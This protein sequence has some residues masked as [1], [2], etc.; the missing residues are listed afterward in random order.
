MAGHPTQQARALIVNLAAQEEAVD[1]FRRCHAAHRARFGMEARV[2]Q[3]ERLEDGLLE[4][5]VEWGAADSSDHLGEQDESSIA[6]LEGG[7]GRIIQY[8]DTGFILLAE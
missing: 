8:S 1:K 6:V 5:A 7:S 3:P 4:I 2:V